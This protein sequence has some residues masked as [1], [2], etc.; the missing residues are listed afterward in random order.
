MFK[1]ACLLCL[2]MLVGVFSISKTSNNDDNEPT[3]YVE[4]GVVYE[5]GKEVE[6][7]QLINYNEETNVVYT[8]NEIEENSDYYNFRE[9]NNNVYLD[10]IKTYNVSELKNVSFDTDEDS[11][12]YAYSLEYDSDENI[13][14]VMITISTVDEILDVQQVTAYPFKYEDGTEDAIIYLEDNTTVYLSEIYDGEVQNCF[15]ITFGIFALGSLISAFIHAVAVVVTIAVV[16][17][18]TYEF[19]ELT[20]KLIEEKEREAAAEENKKNPKCYFVVTRKDDGKILISNEADYLY[21]AEKKI[22]TGVDYWTPFYWLAKTLVLKASGGYVGPEKD[23]DK[24]GYYE[25]YHLANR[26]S[27]GVHAFFGKPAK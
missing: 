24:P 3:S 19:I 1:K 4:D 5:G 13:I 23:K 16:C 22:V 20:R 21:V 8:L 18:V 27:N 10:V 26:A 11:I 15:A 12:N 7:S 25:H 17:G 6:D 14:N 2:S 9:E